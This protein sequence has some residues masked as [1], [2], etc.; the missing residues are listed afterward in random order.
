MKKF[1]PFP[2]IKKLFSIFIMTLWVSHSAIA[3]SPES[4]TKISI[5]NV[6]SGAIIVVW[7]TGGNSWLWGYTPY[8]A[9]SFGQNNNWSIQY[10]NNSTFTFKNVQQNTCMTAYSTSGLTHNSCEAGATNQQFQPILTDS[11]AIQLKSVSLQNKCI[12]TFESSDYKY[13]FGLNFTNCASQ[14][15]EAD[16]K[17]LWALNPATS[18]AKVSSHDEQ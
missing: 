4:F 14:G 13:A 16:S 3:A 9:Q 15:E 1:T 12:T 2:N 10:N 8:D 6:W 18:K 7:A 5:S 17:Q 11:G